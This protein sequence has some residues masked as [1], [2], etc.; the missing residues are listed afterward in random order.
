M[1][2]L[3]SNLTAYLKTQEFSYLFLVISFLGGV[4]ASLS[5]C[6][7]SVLPIVVGYVGGYSEES[8]FKTFLQLLSFVLGLS[9]VLTVIGIICALGGRAFVSI[10]GAYWVLFVASVILLFGLNLLGVIQFNLPVIVKQ[11]PKG[12][13]HSLFIYPFI[14]GA[15]FALAATPCST[16]ILVGIMSFASLSANLVY[17]AL[18]LFMFSLGQGLIIILAGVFTSFVK[19]VRVF[20]GVSEVF[21]K[22]MGVLLVISAF[23]IYFSVF[24]RFF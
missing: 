2:S 11:M 20:S 16:P 13:A 19:K 22:I 8:G 10:G 18:M 12:D 7:L 17:A 24:S 6:S 21:L 4:L 5:P 1:E 9:A 15:L 23:Y 14:L 3:V